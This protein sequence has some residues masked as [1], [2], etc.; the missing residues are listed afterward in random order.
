[1]RKMFY[2]LRRQPQKSRLRNKQRLLAQTLLQNSE[3]SSRIIS[4]K[5][6]RN[7]QMPES[8]LI[9]NDFNLDYE[10]IF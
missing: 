1:M 7:R 5:P 10:G 4:R 2:K 6:N 3:A 9:K 8:K